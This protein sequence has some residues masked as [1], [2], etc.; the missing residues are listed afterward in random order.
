MLTASVHLPVTY[1]CTLRSFFLKMS[2]IKDRGKTRRNVTPIRSTKCYNV[3]CTIGCNKEA[4]VLDVSF[5][6]DDTLELIIERLVVLLQVNVVVYIYLKAILS[7]IHIRNQRIFL[8][9]MLYIT[10][11]HPRCRLSQI[12]FNLSI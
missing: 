5:V 10:Q 12:A 7:Y 4:S 9:N 11:D 1:R 3:V 8:C 6:K 2:E